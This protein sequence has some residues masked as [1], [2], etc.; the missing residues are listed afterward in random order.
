[1]RPEHISECLRFHYTKKGEQLVDNNTGQMLLDIFGGKIA[2]I[3]QWS[4][5]ANLFIFKSSLKA[6]HDHHQHVECFEYECPECLKKYEESLKHQQQATGCG[7]HSP[8]KFKQTILSSRHFTWPSVLRMTRFVVLRP[9]Y[10][11]FRMK[12]ASIIA[13]YK[14]KGPSAEK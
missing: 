8:P 5:P 6:L 7:R 13:N 10:R 1:M 2:N 9:R 14:I 12:S 3:T 11:Y 4:A